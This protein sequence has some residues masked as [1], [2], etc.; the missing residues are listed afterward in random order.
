MHLCHVTYAIHCVLSSAGLQ[1][2]AAPVQMHLHSR[3][4]VRKPLGDHHGRGEVNLNCQCALDVTKFCNSQVIKFKL[5]QAITLNSN[6]GQSEWCFS[7]AGL[8]MAEEPTYTKN[9]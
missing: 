5:L 9:A 3:V 7:D 4:A 8:S 2:P 1:V 6:L